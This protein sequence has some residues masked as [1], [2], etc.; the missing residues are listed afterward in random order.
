MKLF[1]KV[2]HRLGAEGEALTTL[3]EDRQN[4]KKMICEA[5]EPQNE[6]SC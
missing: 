4:W 6:D 5:T 2:E 1:S 3:T